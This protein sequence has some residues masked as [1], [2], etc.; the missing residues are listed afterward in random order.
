MPVLSIVDSLLCTLYTSKAA[1]GA[2]E[3]AN[4]VF[5]GILVR[6]QVAYTVANAHIN[7]NNSAETCWPVPFESLSWATDCDNID[8]NDDKVIDDCS[9]DIVPFPC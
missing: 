2:C 4:S 1:R 8:S 5:N 6:I 9:E 7:W 3:I